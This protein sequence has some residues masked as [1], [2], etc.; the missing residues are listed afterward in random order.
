[1]KPLT[2]LIILVFTLALTASTTVKDDKKPKPKFQRVVAFKF[3]ADASADARKKH[4]KDFESFAKEVKQV[5][6]YRAGKT[7]KG[8]STTEPEYDVMH[9]VT[10]EKEADIV[11]YDIHP[12]HKKFITQNEASWEKVVVVNGEIE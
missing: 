11:A 7:V 5:L 8:E 9:Y 4:M 6:S 12:A 2:Y 10:F 3:K 1:M